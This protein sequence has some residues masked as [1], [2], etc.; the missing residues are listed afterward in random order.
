MFGR[1]ERVRKR[2]EGVRDRGTTTGSFFGE[3]H[4]SDWGMCSW[5]D[6]EE[7]RRRCREK[8]EGKESRGWEPFAVS[9]YVTNHDQ[10]ERE[11]KR[12]RKPSRWIERSKERVESDSR[13]L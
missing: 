12:D 13:K 6:G 1:E 11:E 9:A 2:K 3:H 4:N 7:T 10:K 8:W 5:W